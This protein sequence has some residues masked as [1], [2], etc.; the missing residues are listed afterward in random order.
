MAADGSRTPDV[1][2][3]HPQSNVK[4]K[5]SAVDEEVKGKAEKEK[6][7]AKAKV[8]AL[9]RKLGERVPFPWRC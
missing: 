2:A 6:K 7:K 5:L 4:G 8:G 1:A 3:G 9:V